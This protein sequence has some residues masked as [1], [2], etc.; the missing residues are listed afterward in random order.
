MLRVFCVSPASNRITSYNVC[1]TKLLR[2][3]AEE[4]GL[5]CQLG[6]WVLEEA[7]RQN[8]QW[9]DAGLPQVRI[10]VNVSGYQLQQRSFLDQIKEILDKTG[11]DARWLELEITESVVMQNPEFAI[12]YN[13]V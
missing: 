9:Q 4:S 6:E 2:S 7:C 1:Y 10:A 13:F 3:L 5:I 12:S 11:L 8:K